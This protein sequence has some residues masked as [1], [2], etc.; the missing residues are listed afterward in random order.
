VLIMFDQVLIDRG[1]QIDHAFEHSAFAPALC[2]D[3]EK[4]F[5][6]VGPGRGG[7]RKMEGE[8]RMPVKPGHNF[9]VLMG[10][11]V[12]QHD[13]NVF[14]LG[15]LAS[16]WLRKRMNSWWRCFCMHCPMTEPFRT[17]SAANKVVVPLRL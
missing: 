7:W 1:L 11:V 2:E 6:G 12:V 14:P 15:T 8:A 5:D 13:V 16:I 17:L 9:Q 4:A 10:S 3:A